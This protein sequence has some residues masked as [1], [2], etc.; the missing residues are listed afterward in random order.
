M[1]VKVVIK[2]SLGELFIYKFIYLYAPVFHRYIEFLIN[3]TVIT[4]STNTGETL[5]NNYID[6]IYSQHPLYTKYHD[7]WL[8]Q[9]RGYWGFNEWKD[10]RYMRAYA[11]DMSTP[12]ETMNTYVTNQDG[13]VVSK[14]RANVTQGQSAQST[15]RGQTVTDN[16]FYGEK[17]EATPWFNY[18][19]LITAEYS[20]MLFRNLPQRELPEMPELDGFLHDVDGEGNSVNEFMS[21]VDTYSTV[22]GV[23]HVGCY[24][25]LGSDTPKWKIHTPLD[26]HN[27]EYSYSIEGNLELTKM[28]ICVDDTDEH[29]IYRYLTPETIDTIWCA[30][31]ENDDYAFP[32]EEGVVQIDEYCWQ[33]SQPNEL[34]YVPVRTF[35]QSTKVYNNVGSTVIQDITSICRSIYNMSSEQYASITYGSHP[36]LVVDETTSQLNDGQIGSEPGS[37]ITVQS[38]LTGEQN[39]TYEFKS[40]ELDSIEA[41]QKLIDSHIEKLSQ[42]AMLRSEDLIKASRSGEQIEVYDDKLSAQIRRK[43]TNLENGESKLWGMWADWMNQSPFPVS[44]SYNRQ[45]NK[46]ALEHELK[47]IELSMNILSKY[48]S[49][50]AKESDASEEIYNTVGEATSRAQELGGSGYHTHEEEEDGVS[51]TVYMPFSTHEQLES[52]LGSTSTNPEEESFKTEMRDKIR[53]RLMQLLNSSSSD[54]GI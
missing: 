20:A 12:S 51:R 2:K 45:Y 9:I 26:V 33:Y 39:Y 10:G 25:P 49:M 14:V 42:I 36:T 28:L 54:N 47:E 23:C 22:F 38:S 18:I 53:Q 4:N 29:T 37:V 27:W 6:F 52:A 35:Y 11:I 15:D 7:Q 13:S 48:E 34:G 46:K 30:K 44:I 41:I 16:T 1:S 21:L 24:K 19:K 50:Y 5:A 31:D 8:M 43:A 32:T 17:L 40:P 3:I